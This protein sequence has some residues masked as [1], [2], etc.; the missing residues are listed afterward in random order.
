MYVCSLLTLT[1]TIIREPRPMWVLQA[2]AL[3][4]LAGEVED[5]DG[6]IPR[7]LLYTQHTDYR[8]EVKWLAFS[9][10]LLLSINPPPSAR[11]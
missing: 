8:F 5:D 10:D 2:W 9:L 7:I 11:K 6:R 1:P 4:L 3:G